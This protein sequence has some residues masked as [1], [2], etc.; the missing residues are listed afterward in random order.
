M[1]DV[2]QGGVFL[3]YSPPTSSTTYTPNQFFDVVLPHASRG[4][5]RLV[6]YLIRKTLGWSDAQGNPQN[7]EALVTYKELIEQAGIGRARTREALDEAIAQRYINC[8][9]PGRAHSQGQEG[10]PALYSLNWDDSGNYI[11]DPE[12]FRGFFSGNGNL[13]HIPNQFFDH[14][15][16]HETVAVVKVVGVV[17]RHTIGFQTRFGFRRQQVALSFTEIMRKAGVASRSTVNLALKESI[18]KNHVIRVIPGKFDPYEGQAATYMIRWA[19]DSVFE[20]S[21]KTE[22]ISAG[23]DQSQNRTRKAFQNQ[24][25]QFRNRTWFGS[26]MKPA[27]VP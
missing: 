16:P 9:R 22:P 1:R 10:C 3:G 15:I 27:R 25:N 18:E 19:E 24:T 26:R 5:L 20:E 11:T 12:E 4:C 7:P 13:T 6:A 8:L 17:I 23:D 14:T 2:Q 21:S